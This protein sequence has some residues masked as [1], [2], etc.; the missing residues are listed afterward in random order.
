M[1]CS[2]P[3]KP[4]GDE[5]LDEPKA[6]ADFLFEVSWE[7]CNKVGGIYAVV[8]SKVA[9]MMKYYG[10]GYFVVGPF[11]PKKI[12]GEFEE[13]VPP[14][15]FRNVFERLE[16]E[17][18][19]CY[20]GS[21]LV[22]GEPNAILIDF[23]GFTYKNNL[24]KTELWNNFKVDSLNSAYYDFDEPVIW[25]YA[26]GKLIE[27]FRNEMKDK[28]IVAQFHE[29]LAGAG[30]L[31]LRQNDAPVATVF[32]THATMLG[33][34]LSGKK[35][36]LH[37]K[38]E[39]IDPMKEAYSCGVQPK[40]LMEMECAK[41]ADVFTTVSE[42]TGT[43]VEHLLGIKP[44]VI[45]PNGLDLDLFPTF[46]EAAL[47][48]KL[49]RERIKVFLLYYF[50]P[51]YSFDLDQTL[52]Y[53]LCSRYEFHGKGIDIF[54]K[55]LA[56]VNEQLK[57]EGS[58]K[59][60]VAFFWVPGNV[61]GIR[62]EILENKTY[63]EDVQDNVHD[64]MEDI[65]NKLIALMVSRQEI[66]EKTLLGEDFIYANKKRV[67]RLIR[68]GTPSMTT[69]DLY[70]EGTNEI[71]NAF[72]E[73]GLINREE[74]RVKVIF[75]PIYLTGADGLLDL[76]Y[77]ECIQGSHL[78]VFPSYYEPWGYTP[79]EAAALGVPAV[80][81][82]LAGFGRYI[83]A[84][85]KAS[86]NPGVYVL[87]RFGKKPEEETESLAQILYRY[88]QLSKNDR[89]KNKIE[90]KRRALMADWNILVRNYIYAHNLAV[91]KRICARA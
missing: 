16:K 59:T 21:W 47:K 27:E 12:T 30:L 91:R 2:A 55:A 61:K 7:V 6:E 32:T 43:E 15:A 78:G 25:S 37:E 58:K 46:E 64:I 53:F 65:E 48:H 69:H 38:W 63:F 1:D 19:K 42:T 90:A 8:R 86:E 3:L 4:P 77:Y 26:A 74:D 34:S 41:N 20:Y 5:C 89:T 39:E 80:T 88:S 79:L 9:P 75:Y 36:S 22:K 11:F 87:E 81:T 71:L 50:F 56:K 60:I 68:K 52:F 33:R 83:L 40:H 70:D 57:T 35:I 51:Y 82:D 62:Q 14:V 85:A 84:K 66:S 67:L 44:A 24:I 10:E 17:G 72:R 13:K 49:Y 76:S 23:S 31:Y 45:L 29:W 54:I 28:I 18:I 73:C